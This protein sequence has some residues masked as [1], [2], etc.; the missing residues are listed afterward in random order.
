MSRYQTPTLLLA[1]FLIA[2]CPVV[3]GAEEPIDETRPAAKEARVDIDE[4]INGS[5]TVIGWDR[6]EVTIKG[7]L[8]DNVK[9][10]QF[11][12][13]EK[14]IRFRLEYE[15]GRNKR[16]RGETEL[17]VQVPHGSDVWISGV[18]LTIDISEVLGDL[19]L[20]AVNG[21]IAVHGSPRAV[22]VEN[23]NG[24][25][26]IDASCHSIDVESVS[27]DIILSGARGEVSAATVS[28]DI[29]VIDSDL[30]E[31]DFE[32]VSGSMTF[33]GNLKADGSLDFECHSGTVELSL[34]AGVS[35]EFDLTT[36][37]GDIENDFGPDAERVNRYAPGKELSFTTGA[38]EADVSIETFSGDIVLKKR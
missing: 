31:G 9:G 17:T 23:V 32:S 38:G 26:E 29:E 10:Y 4:I 2:L 35:A 37:S 33:T 13:T 7:T 3:A 20:E 11:T 18:N 30:D 27:G 14:T 5:V 22:E 36:F 34:P 16:S 15:R 21:E 1:I 12:G 25:I 28:G 6:E 24:T 19:E 8:E